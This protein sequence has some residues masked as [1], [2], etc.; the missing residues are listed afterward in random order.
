[1]VAQ[2]HEHDG[3]QHQVED[4]QDGHAQC[5][6]EPRA[7][8]RP[9]SCAAVGVRRPTIDEGG[10]LLMIQERSAGPLIILAADVVLLLLASC[11]IA[12][13]CHDWA[14]G[15]LKVGRVVHLLAAFVCSA[16]YA[17]ND[18]DF[19]TRGPS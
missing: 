11:W 7:T 13:S 4:E 18:A 17:K 6:R 16:S 2:Q 5:R 10:T 12:G 9:A 19:K 3:A 8:G 14:R 15:D 1:M